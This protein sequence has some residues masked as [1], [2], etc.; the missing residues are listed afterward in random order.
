MATSTLRAVILAAAIVIGIVV[1]KNAF[2]EN[3]SQTI[4]PGST[5]TKIATSPSAT[6]STSPSTSA[7]AKP[8]VKGVTVQVLNGTDTTGLA[9]IVTGRLK[10]AGYT[11]K[12]PGGVNNASKT[13]IYYQAGF[14]PEAQFLKSKHF[15][16]AVL[17]P[18]PSSFKSNLTVVLGANFVLS[19]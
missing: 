18:A 1:I 14:H 2:P 6:P 11:M 17:A 13:T 10:R 19:S 15:P 8:R 5:P 4:T 12:T 3:A 7:S 16:G 9:G